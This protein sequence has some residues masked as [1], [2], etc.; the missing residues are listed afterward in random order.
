VDGTYTPWQ[1]IQVAGT[2]TAVPAS[3]PDSGS[4]ETSST[5]EPVPSLPGGPMHLIFNDE[6][7]GTT[8]GST[9]STCWWYS[10]S[11]SGCSNGDGEGEWYTP[12]NVTV[13]NG[14]LNLTAENKP[15]EGVWM[16]SGQPRLY[17]YTSGMVDSRGRFSFTYGYV[18]WKAWLPAGQGLW[19][20]LWMMPENDTWPPEIDALETVGN[21]PDVWTG[22]YHPPSP[23]PAQGFD[24]TVP[25]LSSGWHTF[26]VDWEPGRIT[27]YVDG[28]QMAT[29]TTDVTSTAMYL[30]MD[31]AVG[32]SWPGYPNASTPFPS[33]LR[34]AYVRVW[35][36]STS[37]TSGIGAS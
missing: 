1:T 16:S 24:S 7:T 19:P 31:L 4:S 37:G 6:F 33:T 14:S 18:E 29:T 34:I 5:P 2:S 35:Q 8:L 12:S 21:Q 15:T 27:W 9:W 26:G 23:M 25:G 36:H 13:A 30:V 10:P 20:A 28:Q 32:G 22:T 3:I 17:D 11:P